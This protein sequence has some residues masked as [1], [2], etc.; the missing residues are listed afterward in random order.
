MRIPP[1]YAL[2]C[3]LVVGG[4]GYA[5]YHGYTLFS[6]AAATSRGSYAGGGYHHYYGTMYHK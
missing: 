6:G 4:F 5:K 2:F 3:M 1:A